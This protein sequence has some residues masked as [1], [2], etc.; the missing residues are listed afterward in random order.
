MS[1]ALSRLFDPQHDNALS[2]PR[3][4]QVFKHPSRVRAITSLPH[5]HLHPYVNPA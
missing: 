4:V 5:A 2:P 3:G 1:L